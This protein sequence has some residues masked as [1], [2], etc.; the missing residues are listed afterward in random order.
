MQ[1]YLAVALV[2]LC[3]QHNFGPIYHHEN[4]LKQVDYTQI[5]CK[6]YELDGYTVYGPAG[7]GQVGYHCFPAAGS[8]PEL[9][10][11]KLRTGNIKDGFT[12]K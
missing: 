10:R 1:R 5:E 6:Q 4:M 7:D 3:I 12:Y 9:D 11:I 8:K 2:M